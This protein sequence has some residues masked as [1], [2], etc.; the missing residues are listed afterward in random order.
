MKRHDLPGADVD[1]R[2]PAIFQ[3]CFE[4]D[5]PTSRG[6]PRDRRV[7]RGRRRLASPPGPPEVARA[8]PGDSSTPPGTR[9]GGGSSSRGPAL[10]GRCGTVYDSNS[11]SETCARPITSG[12]SVRRAAV[13][14]A[15]RARDAR[16]YIEG[17]RSL[18]R[19]RRARQLAL[20][21]LSS[22][23]KC[24]RSSI[25]TSSTYQCH[26]ALDLQTTC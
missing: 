9:S 23:R 10:D 13:D 12:D 26:V 11:T 8:R 25:S 6:D 1:Y 20:L 17:A 2:G 18:K 5:G 21:E 15:A 22:T 14:G 7:G 3:R 16:R 4:I 19:T 24:L